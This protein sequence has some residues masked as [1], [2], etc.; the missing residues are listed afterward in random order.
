MP[1]ELAKKRKKGVEKR[2]EKRAG[3]SRRMTQ[4]EV[5]HEI[6]S[7]MSFLK[8]LPLDDKS[9]TGWRGKLG[10]MIKERGQSGLISLFRS[11]SDESRWNERIGVLFQF[12]MDGTSGEHLDLDWFFR[13]RECL[14]LYVDSDFD[15]R[16]VEAWRNERW[17]K[18]KREA[19]GVPLVASE[20]G[21][22]GSQEEKPGEVMGEGVFIEVC[23][24]PTKR[25]GLDRRVRDGKADTALQ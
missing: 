3:K 4:D 7:M 2:S 6:C 8:C 23:A 9:V 19:A 10:M 5:W 12:G 18:R 22:S 17:S 16:V 25:C 15:W 20:R 11:L 21:G 24:M 14:Y 1:V 13:W